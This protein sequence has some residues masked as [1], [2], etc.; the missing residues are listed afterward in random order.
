MNLDLT[1]NLIRR[2]SH[3]LE[4]ICTPDDQDPNTGSYHHLRSSTLRRDT[5][6]DDHEARH[7]FRLSFAT[8][9][10]HHCHV[11]N[12]RLYM[13]RASAVQVWVLLAVCVF[14]EVVQE[15][16]HDTVRE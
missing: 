3:L 13:S 15:P 6:A 11:C 1:D 4:C 2:V 5:V 16:E 10:Q 7:F 12:P 9:R 8:D 14:C